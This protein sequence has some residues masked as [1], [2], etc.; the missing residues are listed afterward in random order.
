M[1]VAIN[2]IHLKRTQSVT[3]VRR[4]KYDCT[5]LLKAEHSNLRA[6]GMKINGLITQYIKVN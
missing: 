6:I 3:W 4:N 5:G 2:H 1:L